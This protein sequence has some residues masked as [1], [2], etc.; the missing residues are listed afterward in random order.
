MKNRRIAVLT[1]IFLLGFALRIYQLNQVPLRG[2]EAFTVIHWVREPLSQ[3]LDEIATKD[4]Q[5]PL[6]YTLYHVWGL[7]V[8]DGEY[9][10]RFLPA[11]LNLLGIP[12]LYALGKRLGGV[13]MG[14]IA[15]LLWAIHPHEIWHAQD[16]RNYAI[17]AAGNA[18]AIWLAFCALEKNKRID[19]VLYVIFAVIAGYLYYLEVFSVAVLTLYVLI[20]YWQTNRTL[21]ARWF[22]AVIVIGATLAIWYLQERL[23][24]SSGYGGTAGSFDL[25]LLFTWF[26]P[27]LT[28]GDTLAFTILGLVL[29][30]VVLL[31][32]YFALAKL[33]KH[34]FIFTTLLGIL[35]L[36]FIAV[37]SLKLAVF[38]PRYVMLSSIAY[39]LSFSG[40]VIFV[41]KKYSHLLAKGIFI[42]VVSLCVFSLS[43]Y[44]LND[45]AK[46]PN[47]RALGQFLSD[48]VT[49]KDIVI[50]MAADEAYTFYHQTYNVDAEMLRLPANPN[51]SEVEI[52]NVL[53]AEL[54]AHQSVWIVAQTPSDWQNNG[55]VE[56]WLEENAQQTRTESID[57]LRAQQ[58]MNWEV[59]SEDLQNPPTP[60][61]MFDE[62]I[63]LI[64][65][66]IAPIS[67]YTNTLSIM[68]YWQQ[69]QPEAASLKVFLH[70]IGEPNSVDGSPLWAQDDQYPQ[71]GRIDTLNP[72]AGIYR[73]V[74]ELSLTNISPG[75]YTLV[76][77]WYDPATNERLSVN[78]TDYYE[79]AE[80]MI[81]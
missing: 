37:V 36:I 63:T 39:I 76:V 51:Q 1:A 81:P 80:I 41:E 66:Q 30:Y 15:A 34:G 22:G 5:P 3:T 75:T 11:L 57:G 42:G 28:F 9:V 70:L 72:I 24:F 67:A 16:A 56:A 17:W 33:T 47:W 44:F 58:Y 45:Y 49:P 71:N 21:V 18:I 35:P 52:T 14:L 10:V 13:K 65:A 61:T 6:A 73:D 54:N 20:M 69:L 26:I 43:N 50:Q 60:L 7:L 31:G 29:F 55:V 77:G 68:L 46:S 53:E 2:D 78:N 12:A 64:D 59:S 4:P 38:V 62:N 27:T 8:G 23:L 79:I 74:Y 19:W 48:T 25:S 40:L 32:G